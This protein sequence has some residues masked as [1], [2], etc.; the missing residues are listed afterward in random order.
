MPASKPRRTRVL[1][2]E[3]HLLVC[4]GLGSLLEPE[5]DLR[6]FVHRGDELLTTL[7]RT[8]IDCLLLD[9]ELPGTNGLQLLPAIRREHPGVAVLVLTMHADRSMA[10]AATGNGAR[11][12]LAKTSSPDELRLAIR[13]VVAGRQYLSPSIPKASRRL[14]LEAR[15]SHLHNLTPRQQEILLLFGEGLCAAEIATRLGVQ[16]STITFH[17]HNMMGLLG[18]DSDSALVRLAVVVRNASAAG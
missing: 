4:H 6:G 8:D 15:Y 10:D 18:A 1:I 16:P 11:G 14:R 3:D 2:A 9:L 7:E 5:F 17:K 13:E 12:F